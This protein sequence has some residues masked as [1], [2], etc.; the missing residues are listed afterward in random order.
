M[1]GWEAQA[2]SRFQKYLNIKKQKLF[3]SASSRSSR[4]K[5]W[6]VKLSWL[7]IGHCPF[8]IPKFLTPSLK[9]EALAN[10]FFPPTIFTTLQRIIE[11]NEYMHEPYWRSILTRTLFKH[12]I[13]KLFV[14]ASKHIRTHHSCL[15]LM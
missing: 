3:L 5:R 9:R 4:F 14:Y 13:P 2:N 1:L 8:P 15:L 7:A 12:V 11:N 10:I 6:D